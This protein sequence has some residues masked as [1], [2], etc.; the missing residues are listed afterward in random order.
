MNPVAA[1][2]SHVFSGEFRPELKGNRNNFKLLTLSNEKPNSWVEIPFQI[3]PVNEQGRL[4]F[5]KDHNWLNES[6]QPQDR[7]VFRSQQFSRRANKLDQFPCSKI[8]VVHE[9]R[10]LENRSYAY[11][12]S[13][14]F[15]KNLYTNIGDNSPVAFDKK[16]SM[17][18]SPQYKYKFNPTNHLLFDQVQIGSKSILQNKSLVD[19]SN[20]MIRSDIKN[21]F[22]FHFD[23][24]DIESYLEETTVGPIGVN[25]RVSFYLKVLYLFTI[26]L[27]L[28][29]DVSFYEDSA[30][31][32]MVIHIPESAEGKLNSGSGIIYSWNDSLKGSGVSE[33]ISPKFNNE[34]KKLVKGDNKELGEVG[35]KSCL[36]YS[37]CR[38]QYFVQNHDSMFKMD[39]TIPRNLV[40]VGFFPLHVE[41]V[42]KYNKQ[43]DWDVPS[44]KS[45]T[46]GFYFE[47]SGLKSGSHAWDFWLTLNS[48]FKNTNAKCPSP[49][50][51]NQLTYPIKAL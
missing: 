12:V 43:M 42:D 46:K 1:C 5:Y 48:D 13:C 25:A 36:G 31:I 9:I 6:I 18:T 33:S 50:Y 2:P 21:F 32:P 11:L 14:D 51:V 40:S 39:F 24:D 34:I 23:K 16:N 7:L 17:I 37:R 10:S 44:Q 30:N 45:G 3:D 41:N 20:I 29:T 8:S 15:K 27:S 19:T 26:K 38:F 22:T 49:V 4:I 47:T 28:S 35:L